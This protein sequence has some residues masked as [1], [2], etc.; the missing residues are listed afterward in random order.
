M[1]SHEPVVVPQRGHHRHTD[2]QHGNKQGGHQPVKDARQE[3][4]LSLILRR[5]HGYFPT[6][7]VE[8][9][10]GSLCSPSRRVKDCEYAAERALS[11]GSS[12]GAI[13]AGSTSGSKLMSR[14]GLVASL[15]MESIVNIPASICFRSGGQ[16]SVAS[17]V[18]SPGWP[19]VRIKRQRRG[20]V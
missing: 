17:A 7:S 4:E 2:E 3:R 6:S 14:V 20:V 8:T 13:P 10:L 9:A 18:G 16:G 11:S 5:G 15:S 19:T 1:D 12:D